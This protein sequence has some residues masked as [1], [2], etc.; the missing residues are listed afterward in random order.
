M[1]N[2]KHYS[3]LLVCFLLALFFGQPMLSQNTDGKI[4]RSEEQMELL[5]QANPSSRAEQRIL[6]RLVNSSEE[7]QRRDPGASYVIPVVFHVFGTTFNSG[8]VVND[9]LIK[10]ALMKTNED[11]HG[12]NAKYST[13]APPFD[14]IKTPL[15]VTFRLAQ[16]DPQGNPTSGIMYYPEA[17]GMGNYDSPVVA[18]VAWDNSKYMNVYITRD[19]YNDGDYYN[20]GVAWLPDTY[21]TNNNTARVV[22]NG[23]YLGTNTDDNFRSILTHE[24]G[25]FLDLHHTF[26]GG[27]CNNN[28]LD[29]DEVADTPSHINNSSGTNCQVIYNCLNQQINNE[30]F[31]DYTDCYKMF[32]RGQVDRMVNA[33]DNSPARNTLWTASNLAA[34]GLDVELGPRIIASNSFFEERYLNDGVVESVIELMATEAN[35]ALAAGEYEEG[36]HYIANNVPVGMTMKI[37]ASNSTRAIVALEGIS[38]NHQAINTVSDL[39]IVFLDPMIEGGVSLLYADTLSN[40][41]VNFSDVYTE[42]CQPTIGYSGYTYISNVTFD[43]RSNETIN[44]YFSDYTEELSYPVIPGATYP[45]SVT[46]NRGDGGDPDNLRIQVWIDWNSNFVFEDSELVASQAYNNRETDGDGDY[47]YTTDI[48]IPADV[49]LGK[50]AI[51]VMAHFVMGTDGDTACSYIDSGE[52]EDYG[53]NIL[54]ESTELTVEFSGNPKAVNFSEPVSFADLSIPDAGD[55]ISSWL[56]TFEGASTPTSTDQNPKNIFYTEGGEF[57]VTLEVTTTNGKVGTLTKPDYIKSELRYCETSPDYGS[58]FSVN[59]VILEDISHNPGKSNYYDYF[60]SVTTDL[61]AGMTYPMTITS[62][63]G[64]GGINDY[65]RVK[66]WADWNYDSEFSE[67]E[68]LIDRLVSGEDYDENGNYTFTAD[69]LVPYG[70]SVGKRVALR[71]IGHYEDGFTGPCGSFDSGNAID[72][73]IDIVSG[74]SGITALATSSSEEFSFTEPLVFTDRSSSSSAITNWEWTF[75]GGTPASFAGQNPPE[76]TYDEPG[77]YSYSLTV[78]NAEGE[79]GSYTGSV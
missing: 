27:I 68:L 43:G 10:D 76:I 37:S 50:I 38:E 70:A 60:D 66:V 30:N 52:V 14:V 72:Y 40:L 33:L 26:R 75:E 63:L 17:G 31:M 36:L 18:Q 32:T 15:D 42:A 22:Y 64:D 67:S 65:N 25:H 54:D 77:I 55:S 34:T 16:L 49:D 3:T 12:L 79:T 59:N 47:T 6:S 46:T 41:V 13:I 58:Y 35:F 19:L 7:I 24:F 56:W 23:S 9:A 8:T 20:S 21:M 45:L 28:P 69:I 61:A 74:V 2:F 73:G 4:C 5:Y 78:T 44:N 53:L 71:V 57:D 29:G 11:F 39:E 51:R 1:H 48:Q 62:E